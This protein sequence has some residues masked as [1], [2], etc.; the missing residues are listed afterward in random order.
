M[1]RAPPVAARAL[2]RRRSG[3]SLP[4]PSETAG[5]LGI[6]ELDTAQMMA[7]AVVVATPEAKIIIVIIMIIINIYP[8]NPDSNC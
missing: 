2:K 4:T 7:K 6:N 3:T 1:M 8:D 5:R